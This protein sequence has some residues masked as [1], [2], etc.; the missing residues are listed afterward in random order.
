VIDHSVFRDNLRSDDTFHALH[1]DFTLRDS[2]FLRANSDAIDLDISTGLI[3]ANTIEQTGGDAIDLMT[4]TPVI[5]DNLIRG[6]NDK[7]ISV[8]EASRPFIL[9]NHIEGCRRGI[10]VKDQS[11]PTV[12][13]NVL[14]HN[15][16]GLYEDR[17]NWRYGGGG[18]A[19]VINSTLG[20]NTDSLRLDSFSH[21][22][23]STDSLVGSFRLAGLQPL[24][25]ERFEEDLVSSA[26]GWKG[27]GGVTRVEKIGRALHAAVER[28]PG[29]IGK[30]VSWDLRGAAA[31]ATLV[32]ALAT[33]SLDSGEVR[34]FSPDGEFRQP[35]VLSNDPAVFRQTILQLPPRRY[36]AIVITLSPSPRIEKLVRP[37]GW[38]EL[39][40]G[41]FWLQGYDLYRPFP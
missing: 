22:T 40:P 3:A 8:G 29:S 2:H 36:T 37:A 14:V 7:G 9:D 5:R 39:K 26:D 33:H 1:S 38:T 4:S 41:Q 15:G 28:R 30:A 6:S 24:A 34:V 32:L 23:V 20:E 13:N 25:S 10:E 27:T 18:W 21:I 11:E 35:V 19:T 31:P 16:T 17:K 12:L